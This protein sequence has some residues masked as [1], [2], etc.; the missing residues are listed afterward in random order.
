MSSSLIHISFFNLTHNIYLDSHDSF[1]KPIITT[2]KI[3]YIV[4]AYVLL[5]LESWHHGIQ[6]R[7]K[8]FKI[9][10]LFIGYKKTLSNTNCHII[11]CYTIWIWTK[12][13]S[14]LTIYHIKLPRLHSKMPIFFLLF[15]RAPN[16]KWNIW[17]SNFQFPSKK[18]IIN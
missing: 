9:N 12:I 6:T 13:L 16:L 1:W 2:T 5:H 18:S 10:S 4:T 7:S 11:T 14:N 15:K 17:S 8:K 3:I